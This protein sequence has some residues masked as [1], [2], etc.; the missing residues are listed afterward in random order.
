MCMCCHSV[1]SNSVWPH[2]LLSTRLLY[3]WDSPGKNTGVGFHF[4]LQWDLPN[5]IVYLKFSKRID[6]KHSHQKEKI[7]PYDVMK[8]LI[9]LIMVIILQCIHISNHQIVYFKYIQFYVNYTSIKVGGNYE[10]YLVCNI[11]LILRTI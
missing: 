8:V 11:S 3:P 9:Y 5:Y 7:W 2:G 1:M 6:L 4:F 10:L